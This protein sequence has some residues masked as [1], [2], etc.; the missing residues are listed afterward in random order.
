MG[1]RLKSK[2]GKASGKSLKAALVRHQLVGKPKTTSATTTSTKPEESKKP[3][4]S[5]QTEQSN[6][7]F[8]PFTKTDT[9]LLV[10]EGDLSFAVSCIK[11]GYVDPT[12]LI[13]T[14]YDAS[15][16]ELI[17]KYPKTFPQNNEFLKNEGI[18]VMYKVDAT[19]LIRSMKVKKTKIFPKVDFIVFNFPHTGRGMKDMDRNIRDHQ[20]LVLGYF[21][22]SIE[23]FGNLEKKNTK[24][25]DL[26]VM[27]KEEKEPK[28]VLSV[29]EG[30]P[31]DSWNIKSLSKTLG[32]KVERS[33]KFQWGAFEGYEHK[34]TNSEQNT[35]KV[36]SE[37]NA[38]IYVFEK[39]KKQQKK[40]VAEDSD[41]E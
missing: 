3:K 25:S 24:P 7:T 17:H 18:E 29:F 26:N 41:E 4:S 22:S 40:K 36:A 10:G 28:I 9:V 39:F 15:P 35:T 31:Y 27:G 6:K 12:K 37:R 2:P 30:E 20:L 32:L 5:Q 14:S 11:S 1:K 13:V 38:K 16:T 34:R 23:L 21:K 33:G 8:I 19:D